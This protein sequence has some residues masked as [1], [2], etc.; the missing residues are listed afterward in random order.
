MSEELDNKK[1]KA[2]LI[3]HAKPEAPQAPEPVSDGERKK[4]VVV[5][6][7][8]AVV[9][10]VVVAHKAEGQGESSPV[11]PRPAASSSPV[12]GSVA[13]TPTP[14]SSE[15]RLTPEKIAEF[16]SKRPQEMRRVAPN[17]DRP[18]PEGL[19]IESGRPPREPRPYGDR[20]QGQWG[21][22]RPQGERPQ[23]ERPQGQWSGPPLKAV[24]LETQAVRRGPTATGRP[25]NGETALLKVIVLKVNGTGLD[26]RVV[27]AGLVG[28]LV[29][30]VIVL[31]VNGTGLDLR[32]ARAVLDTDL[33]PAARVTGPDLAV[34]VTGLG[35]AARVTGPDLAVLVTGLG[36]AARAELRPLI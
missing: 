15:S 12:Q 21:G 17:P 22:P 5:V 25:I 26:L 19:R 1:P 8:K 29:P 11:Q 35:P 32:V 9:K 27:R 7:K 30:T 13:K 36:P 6:K 10:K 20:P 31:K 24:L 23:G 4:T 28:R 3:K 14:G 33:G 34:L 18:K 2:T 16:A